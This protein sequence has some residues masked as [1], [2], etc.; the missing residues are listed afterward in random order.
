[1]VEVVI[2]ITIVDSSSSDNNNDSS[3]SDNNRRSSGGNSDYGDYGNSSSIRS[4]RNCVKVVAE[5]LMF[6]LS[7][8]P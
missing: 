1:M 6:P 7:P 2:T 3:S 8:S 4:D 5:V